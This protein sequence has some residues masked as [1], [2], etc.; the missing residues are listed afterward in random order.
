MEKINRDELVQILI[1]LNPIDV[2]KTCR[3]HSKFSKICQRND[4]F[5]NLM[6]AHYPEWIIDDN[7]KT[8][9][10]NITG[11]IGT[12]YHINTIQNDNFE[13]LKEDTQGNEINILKEFEYVATP[14]PDIKY[15]DIIDVIDES[16]HEQGIIFKILG[17]TI[18][19][20]EIIA[21]M[22]TV[23]SSG[24]IFEGIAY[25]SLSNAVSSYVYKN[26]KNL[27]DSLQHDFKSDSEEWKEDFEDFED[28]L[29]LNKQPL[30]F[31]EEGLY[32]YIMEN[33]FYERYISHHESYENFHTF[34]LPAG[35]ME[36]IQFF[37]V[38][39]L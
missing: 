39:I 30:N 13:I 17:T 31:T 28:Y 4:V 38:T 23:S 24:K 35:H 20:G 37:E 12:Y 14:I 19:K 2:L 21:I 10:I 11:N 1:K 32:E 5:V 29:R 3:T 26:F 22:V 36:I 8:Q 18:K 6:E 25:D 7:A 16:K 33:G 34:Y 27:H 9:Y 15:E